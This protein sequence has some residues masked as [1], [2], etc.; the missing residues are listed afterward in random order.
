MNY[1][2]AHELARS[3]K[4]SAEYKMFLVAQK[5]V[6]ETP[7]SNRMLED[8]RQKQFEFQMKQMS[9]QE[10]SQ[11]EIEQIQKLYEII[12]LNDDIRKVLEAERMLGQIME[13]INRIIAEPLQALYGMGEK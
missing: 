11:E 12:Q 7:D 1:D 3:I 10:L 2:K 13:D 8:F 5:K 6:S 4:E 9:G